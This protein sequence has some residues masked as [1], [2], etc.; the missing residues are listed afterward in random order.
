MPQQQSDLL[1]GVRFAKTASA[2][3]QHWIIGAGL[4][5]WISLSLLIHFPC[6]SLIDVHQIGIRPATSL[7]PNGWQPSWAYLDLIAQGGRVGEQ[8]ALI[9]V[10]LSVGGDAGLQGVQ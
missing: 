4:N 10:G 3:T 5:G 7:G 6:G 2:F 9:I 1:H 8:L